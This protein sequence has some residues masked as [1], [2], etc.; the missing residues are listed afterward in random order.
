MTSLKAKVKVKVKVA[1]MCACG[2]KDGHGTGH[3]LMATR[4]NRLHM[5]IEAQLTTWGNLQHLWP[6]IRIES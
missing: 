6:T 3:R 5:L 4:G 1:C 2:G